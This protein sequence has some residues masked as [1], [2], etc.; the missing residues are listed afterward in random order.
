MLP[1]KKY[2]SSSESELIAGGSEKVTSSLRLHGQEVVNII[3]SLCTC[4]ANKEEVG[5]TEGCPIIFKT[6]L[7]ELSE[8][9]L[10]DFKV[11]GN[12]L[13]S[14]YRILR[15]Q[16]IHRTTHQNAGMLMFTSYW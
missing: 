15:V 16:N 11:M 8:C 6:C 10:K 3:E 1:I 2:T 4:T 5:K 14:K 12:K 7:L 9:S 13:L